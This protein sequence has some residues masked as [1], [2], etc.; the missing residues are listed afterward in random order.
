MNSKLKSL[1]KFFPNAVYVILMTLFFIASVLLYEPKGLCSLFHAG[2]GHMHIENVYY[3]NVTICFCIILVVL[4]LTRMLLYILRKSISLSHNSYFAVC[5]AELVLISAFI[6]LYLSLVS[7]STDSYFVFLMK[8]LAT[9]IPVM[10]IPQVFHYLAYQLHDARN[11][12][13]LDEG[14]RLKFYDSRH[15]LKFITYASSVLFIESNENYI[16]IHYLDAGVEKKYQLRNTM[17]SVEGLSEKAGFVRV[18]RG[19]IV[20]PSHV[21]SVRKDEGGLYF[22]DL[23]ANISMEVPVS[24]RYYGNITA[25]L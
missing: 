25:L 14:V 22:A 9:I 10:V 11:S 21:K 23:G 6:A 16:N 7:A 24:K 18:H 2:E 13:N 1:L 5:V 15:L 3:F 4:F 17:K 12:E 8:C 19:Y 20:N